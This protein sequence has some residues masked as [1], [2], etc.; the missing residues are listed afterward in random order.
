MTTKDNDIL[1]NLEN[2]EYK[3]GFLTDVEN[4]T[5]LP[6]IDEEKIKLI[7]KKKNE[8]DFMLNF[9]LDAFKKWQKM[10]EPNWGF[11]KY[12][13]IDYDAL[14]YYSAPKRRNDLKSLDDVDP[15]VLKT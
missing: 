13:K 1:K 12:E 7:S 2:S 11:L 4:D 3:Y 8:P 9:R 10:K 15:E 5:V 6:G 14:S